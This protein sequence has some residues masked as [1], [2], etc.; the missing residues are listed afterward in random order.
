MT[1]TPIRKILNDKKDAKKNE[2]NRNIEFMETNKDEM[3][4]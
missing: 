3:K 1:A 4:K 2:M